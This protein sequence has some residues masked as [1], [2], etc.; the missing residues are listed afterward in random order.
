M[1]DNDGP[2]TAIEKSAKIALKGG[3]YPIMVKYFQMGGGKELRLSWESK[4]IEK[5]QI[6]AE[7]LFHK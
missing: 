4:K 2:H 7:V 6:T 1:I 5:Q 3:E